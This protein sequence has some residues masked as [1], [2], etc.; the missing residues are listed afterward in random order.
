MDSALQFNGSSNYLSLGKLGSFGSSL[1]NGFY[2]AF[3][4]RSAHSFGGSFGVNGTGVTVIFNTAGSGNLG[5]AMSDLSNR[6]LTGY[7]VATGWND[8]KTHSIE[9]TAVPSTNT[10]AVVV[11]GSTKTVTYTS[12]ATPSTFQNFSLDFLIGAS[13][14]VTP[15]GYVG[16]IVDDVKIGNSAA[17]I[18]ASYNLNEN[19]GTT[20]ADTSGN[21]YT[22]TLT[23]SPLPAWVA[24]L[25]PTTPALTTE[26][27]TN[28]STVSVTG[29][30]TLVTDGN[31]TLTEKG[32]VWSLSANPTTSDNKQIVAGSTTGSFFSNITGLSINT[33][34]HYR[35][36][37][38]N[39]QGTSYGSDQSFTTLAAP[40]NINLGLLGVG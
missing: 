25:N 34:Y 32:F 2:I 9:L 19:S 3:K 6:K 38:T 31:T 16:C 36:Y 5:L 26:A 22:G 12:Q 33:T 24:G 7:A 13:G 39:A 37:A 27:A 23:G 30:G 10:I 8:S 17:S 15:Q 20:T 1:G 40:K 4:I 18:V 28:I 11:D 29:N 35:A 14:N 21:G